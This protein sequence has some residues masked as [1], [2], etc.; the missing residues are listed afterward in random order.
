MAGAYTAP[1]GISKSYDASMGA[2]S[3]KSS[4]PRAHHFAPQCWLAGFT[5]SGRKDGRL[6]VTDLRRRKQ[7][8][9]SPPNAGHQRDFYRISDP[10]ADPVAFERVFSQ[11]EDVI[12]PIFR[13]LYDE[14]R[15]PAVEE[16]DGLLS[17]AALQYIRVP[18][19]RPVLLKI[20]DS[21][22][23]SIISGALKSP[24][25]WAA[26]LKKADIVA[27]SPGSDYESMQKFEREVIETGEY[28]LTAG[29][30]FYL[31]RGFKVAASAIVPGLKARYWSTIVSSSGSFIASDNPVV[32]DGPKDRMMGFKSADVV[33]FVVN[34]H[35]LLC[36]T[37]VPVRRPFINRKLIARHNTFFML[38][39]EEQLYSHVANFCWFDETGR[40]RNDW[41]GFSKENVLASV[42]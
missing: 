16:L 4:E 9:S 33:F 28:E 36:G 10:A 39:A 34:R 30:E 14:P 8:P 29:N 25:T 35:V 6:F 38:T 11:I 7:W 22:N 40:V 24:A 12:A 1:F 18:A 5:D 15:E 2:S 19:F 41:E 31:V 3:N 23:R 42:T 20:A 26:A 37:K 21:I 27:D 13:N 17:F 32:M